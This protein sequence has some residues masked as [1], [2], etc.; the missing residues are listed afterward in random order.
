VP[1]TDTRPP[2]AR[3]SRGDYLSVPDTFVDHRPPVVQK[4]ITASAVNLLSFYVKLSVFL[5]ATEE[6]APVE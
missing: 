4:P 6:R 3:V 1:S 2:L 5:T